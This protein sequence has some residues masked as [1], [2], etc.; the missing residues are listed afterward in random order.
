MGGFEFVRKF[1]VVFVMGGSEGSKS[2]QEEVKTREGNQVDGKFAK[3][4]VELTG[5]TK[6]TSNAAHHM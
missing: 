1:G 2:N 4:S 3:I 6:R 5:E